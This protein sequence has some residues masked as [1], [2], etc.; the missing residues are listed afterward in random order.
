MR[1]CAWAA[2]VDAHG[3]SGVGGSLAMTLPPEVAAMIRDGVELGVA[4]DR[5]VGA[6]D[7]KQVEAPWAF[8]PAESS[9][10]SARMRCSSPMRWR[11]S[12]RAEH[13]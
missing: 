9:T 6:H 13:Y 5:L 1:T 4:M 11:R 12:W 10:A 3:R 2:I 8:S 7:T